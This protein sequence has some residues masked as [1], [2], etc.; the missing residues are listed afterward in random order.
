VYVVTLL[1]DSERW[2]DAKAALLYSFDTFKV[3]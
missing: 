1:T 2:N 3:Y